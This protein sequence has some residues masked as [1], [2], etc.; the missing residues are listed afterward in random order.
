MTSDRASIRL[1][2]ADGGDLSAIVELER[3]C[4]AN[5][6]PRSAFLGELQL[7]FASLRV[8]ERRDE[9]LGF[10]DWWVVGEELH[11]LVLAVA[12]A[13]RRQRIASLLV[14]DA[15]NAAHRR[16][17]THALLEVRPGNVAAHSFYQGLGYAQVGVKRGYY[18]DTA[19]DALMWMK[20]LGEEGDR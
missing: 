2:P 8:A 3:I 7:P 10:I 5:P 19:E 11:L 12:E 18:S 6:W 13:R 4:F 17:A 14:R 15:E 9:L 20:L 16:G 1:R